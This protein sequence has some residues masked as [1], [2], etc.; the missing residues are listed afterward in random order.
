MMNT[1]TPDEIAGWLGARARRLAHESAEHLADEDK[2]DAHCHSM[3][4]HFDAQVLALFD[5]AAAVLGVDE[6]GRA[7]LAQA[8]GLGDWWTRVYGGSQ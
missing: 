3:C 1:M 5:A 2:S 4:E 8:L 7:G 6:D